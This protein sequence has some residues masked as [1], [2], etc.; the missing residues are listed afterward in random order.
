LDDKVHM[1]DGPARNTRRQTQVHAITQEA[2]WSYIHNYGKVMSHPVAVHRAAHQQYPTNM[3]H[4]VLDKTTG[5]LMEMQHLLVNPKYKELWGKYYTK[6]LGCLAQGT[7]EVS[8]IT[9][10]IVFIHRK[11][12]PHN[13]KCNITYARVYVNYCPEKEDP[14]MHM[15]HHRRQSAPLPW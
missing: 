7:P 3:L 2:L 15:S 5:H 1:V 8:K 4:T 10:T 12:I 9:N 14:Q 13:H 11:D 6:E